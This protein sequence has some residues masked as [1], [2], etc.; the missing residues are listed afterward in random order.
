[1]STTSPRGFGVLP[2]QRRRPAGGPRAPADDLLTVGRR[3]DRRASPAA[4]Q[5]AWDGRP[6]GD[7]AI[8]V[9]VEHGDVHTFTKLSAYGEVGRTYCHA[10]CAE[11]IYG[12]V[13]RTLLTQM[14]VPVLVLVSR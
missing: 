4:I 3:L 13:T 2:G 8:S 10:R 7:G 6:K 1:M 11:I 14:P 5:F 12:A 9:V